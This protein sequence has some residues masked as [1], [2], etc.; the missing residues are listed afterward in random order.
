MG[1]GMARLARS[2]LGTTA[3]VLC[4][5]PALAQDAPEAADAGD[6]IV[7]ATRQGD[8]AIS[9]V[10]MSIVAESQ[11]RL[12]QQA[13]KTAQD[14][15]RI[16]PALRIEEVSASSSNISIRGVRS[17][18][19]S[20]TTGVYIDDTALQARALR[21]TTS[22]G[23]VFLPPI[24]D[25]E[26]VEVLKGPQGTLYGGSSQGG[27][28]RFITPAPN[29]SRFSVTARTEINSVDHGDI[30]YEG[31]LA[32]NVPLV[33][34]E[35]GLRVS[36]FHRRY[37]GYID[38]KDRRDTSKIV[39]ENGNWREQQVFR[40]ALAW[41][42][43]DSLRITPAYYFARDKL[44]SLNEVY[45]SIPSYTTPAYGT[46]QD[47]AP[48]GSP[49]NA[50]GRGSPLF[51]RYTG[52]G[53]GGGLLPAGYTPP[54]G[55]GIV[56]DIPG[57][58]GRR[59]FIHPAHT[60]PALNLGP[61]DSIE[62][63]NVGDNYTGPI[64]REPSG[65]INKMHLGSLTLD[66]DLGPA[67]LMSVTSYLKDSGRGAFASALISSISVT[68]IP[69]YHPSVNTPYL[70][71]TVRPITSTFFFDAERE[72][73]SQE[74]RLT[75]PQD[76]NGLSFV[77]GVYYSDASTVSTNINISDRSAPREA[78]FNIGQTFFPIHSAAQIASNNQ[79]EQ[80]QLLDET[81][82]ALYGEATYAVTE[83]LKLIA[84]IRFSREDI[85][86]SLRTWGLLTNSPF[87]VGTFIE[88]AAVEHPITPKISIAYQ[89]TPD[90][91]FYATVSKGYRP[92]GVQGQ[93]NPAICANDMAALNITE[94]PSSYGSDTVWNYEAGAKVRMFDR[95]LQLSGSVFYVQW[96][97]P[98]TPYRL[99]TCNFEYVTNI[100]GAY[101]RGFD[102][103]GTLR[104]MRGLTLDFSVGYTD[105]RFTQ[106]VYTLPN[107]Q[108]ERSLLVGKDMRLLEVPAWTGTVGA[109]YD[110]DLNDT[111]K[112]YVFGAYQYTGSYTNTLGPGVLSY[113]PDVFKTPSIDNV[114]ARLGVSN[115]TFDISLFVDNLFGN[116]T[117]R[118]NDLV[119]R[120][121]CRTNDCSIYGTYYPLVH[122]TTMRP[123]TIGLTVQARY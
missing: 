43:S 121:S 60:Y 80:V 122:G 49:A 53:P 33:T 95:A 24:F 62:V 14:I 34:D 120:T 107:D 79:Q 106:D 40:A 81:S 63:T 85:R 25:L 84:G 109:R 61:Y 114:T 21:G 73:K 18:V 41:E 52:T 102:L 99:P 113:S 119:G 23:G 90:N 54:P 86:Y 94:T 58:E 29:L 65:R 50:P 6:I 44:N 9:R 112:S 77:A 38:Y 56:T 4:M 46:Y 83:K 1:T 7:T 31:G 89:A 37:G 68:A 108:G 116:K 16:V 71:D 66:W 100:G 70:F 3:V 96:N 45:R 72:A 59:V 75:Y 19:G 115:S 47:A 92:G 28:V 87:G 10:P 15:S 20:A 32:V 111:W 26:R 101:S 117:L 42:P 27:T 55:G 36:G 118:P 35:L 97:K 78:A 82:M 74:I 91:L 11:E 51:G 8:I 39:E 123:R 12:D 48:A 30:G 64:T 104:A 17:E 69:G 110:F 88:G 93:A 13:I 5:T 105:A 76:D 67:Q 103:Q 57:A 98:Q 2:L 22:G